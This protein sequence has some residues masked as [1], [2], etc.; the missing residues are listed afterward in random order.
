MYRMYNRLLCRSTIVCHAFDYYFPSKTPLAMDNLNVSV[1]MTTVCNAQRLFFISLTHF[2]LPKIIINEYVYTCTWVIGMSLYI[3]RAKQSR[4]YS[5][6]H[7]WKNEWCNDEAVDG[8]HTPCPAIPIPPMTG[9][10]A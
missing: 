7:Q 10:P 2:C 5:T 9:D 6:Q 8:A 3:S 1:S 4:A